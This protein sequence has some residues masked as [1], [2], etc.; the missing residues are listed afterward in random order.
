MRPAHRG[1]GVLIDFVGAAIDDP[2]RLTC[3]TGIDRQT[4]RRFAGRVDSPATD[5][6]TAERVFENFI[7][8]AVIDDPQLAAFGD[9]A[10]GVA[11]TTI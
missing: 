9:D 8:R 11:V 7:G 5:Q 2:D 4:G 3:A 1:V 10:F 6:R